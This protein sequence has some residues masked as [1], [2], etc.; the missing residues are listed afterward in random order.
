LSA[1][2]DIGVTA[3]L[4][5]IDDLD[6]AAESDS[7]FFLWLRRTV[8]RKQ[9]GDQALL[10]DFFRAVTIDP[11]PAATP[12]SSPMMSPIVVSVEVVTCG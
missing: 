10:P 9:I 11:N 3:N 12:M 8:K 7:S 6:M 5:I 4:W 2:V 1:E